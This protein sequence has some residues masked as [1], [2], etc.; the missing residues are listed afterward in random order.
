MISCQEV[1]KSVADLVNPL[2]GSNSKRNFS[3][4]NTYPAVARPWGN[5][6]WTP[7][8]RKNGD[9]WQFVYTDLQIVGFKQTHQPSPWINDYGCWSIMPQ[10]GNPGITCEKRALTYKREN[11]ISKPYTYKVLFDNGIK[12]EMTASKNGAALS[13]DYG[14]NDDASLVIDCFNGAGELRVDPEN[15][16]IIGKSRWYANNNNAV[17][18]ENFATHFILTFDKKM[19]DVQLFRKGKEVEG[20]N[21]SGNSVCAKISFGDVRNLEVRAASSFISTSQAELNMAR[22]LSNKSFSSLVKEAKNAWNEELSVITVD[23]KSEEQLRTFYTAMY[24]T[25]LFPR[26]T[27]EVNDEGKIVHYSF[28]TG[29]V[30]DGPMYADNGFWDTFRAVHPLFTI[31]KPSLTAELMDALLNIY[32]EGGWLPEWFSPAYKDCMIGQHSASVIT[33]AYLKGIGNFDKEEMLEA[34][35]KSAENDGPNATGR[36]GIEEYRNFGYIPTDTG[37]RET[38]SNTLEYAYND[39]CIYKYAEKANAPEELLRK[40]KERAF[41]YKNIF[42]T[43][44][45]FVRPRL[46]NGQW[47]EEFTA[48]DWSKDFTEGSSWHWTWSVFHDPA[49]LIA[50]MGGEDAFTHQL[51]SV[52]TAAPTIGLGGRKKSIHEMD[53]MVACNMGQYAHGNQP[54]QH[55]PYLYSYAGKPYMTQKRIHDITTRLYHSGI[56]DGKGLCGDEDNGQTSAWYIFSALG[57]YPV[58]PSSGEYIIGTPLF[59]HA[60]MKLENGKNFKVVAKNINSNNYY[61]QSATLNGKIFERSFITH[62]EIMAGGELKFIMGPTPNKEWASTSKPFSLSDNK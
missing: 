38:V 62:D 52:F 15:N 3:T 35:L 2:Q 10:T 48:D 61:I 46:K 19:K 32:H 56:K 45:H 22:E 51:D 27:H 14:T 21:C 4:G 34:I 30:L 53:E 20:K 9:G 13:F 50:L 55:M 23:G 8:S 57:F 37:M 29:E 59:E 16:R 36:V 12:T 33:D 6:F 41:N 24:R 39:Y 44:T 26:K 5:N 54:I 1:G 49:G 60:E 58:C 17:L 47:L 43:T 18:P 25:M 40:Y 11:E 31:I 7:Q 28:H 42:D